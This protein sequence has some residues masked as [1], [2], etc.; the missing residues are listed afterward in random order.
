MATVDIV[1]GTHRLL[2]SDVE[3]KNLGLLVVDEEHRFGV[4]HKERIKQMRK[5]V[6]VLTLTATP[7]P[8]TLQLSLTG[9]RDLSVIE[10]P[11]VDRLAIRTYVTRYDE[12]LI[13]EA[14]L[15]ELG[16]G[17]QVFFVHNRVETIE[18]MGRRICASSCRRRWSRS[19]TAR[20]ASAELEKVMLDFIAAEGERSGL[21]RDHRVGPRHPERQHHHHQ[22]RRP[23]R[24]GAA[25]PAA[26]PRRPLA[27]SGPTLI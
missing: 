22:P 10:T 3:F 20:C 26:R 2:Q 11:P 15:R 24:P 27:R 7:I 14:I 25:L 17:G 5:L 13:R 4:R 6:D 23:F 19:P 21:H 16:R 18:I 12:G 9:I 8:R 1:I